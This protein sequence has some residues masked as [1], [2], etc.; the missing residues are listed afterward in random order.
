MPKIV[1]S[2]AQ[3]RVIRRAAR[4]VFSRRG[5]K[6]AGLAH[7]ARL[8]GI[9]RASIY[10]Y[11]PDKASLVRDLVRELLAEEE[12][13]FAAALRNA[14]GSALQRIEHLAGE[15][16]Q[17]FADWA[18]LGKMLM[19]LWSTA[20]GMFR[21]FFRRI[22]RDLAELIAE[23]QV[24]GEID[25]DLDPEVA[26]AAVIALIDGMLLQKMVDAGALQDGTAVREV[27]VR[28]ARKMLRAS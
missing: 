7:V 27:L 13:F 16:T 28:C 22:R 6:A 2:E 17:L 21:P 23:G 25:R 5:V 14:E 18:R 8:A 9:A 24:S 15:L 26:A 11:Y 20:A 19:E 4:S 1:D 12:S 10:H 3:R